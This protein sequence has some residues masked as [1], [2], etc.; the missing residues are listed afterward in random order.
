MKFS[1]TLVA[2]AATAAS[3][4]LEPITMKGS[5]LFYTNGTQFFMKGVAY[6][7]DTAAAGETNDKTTKYI[8]PLADEEA[9]KRD[10]PL[11]KELGTNIIRTYA[12]NPKADHK[13]CMKMLDDAGIYVVS[14]LSE[15]SVSINRDDPKWDIELYER[16]IGVVDELAQYD[17]VVG[18]F[19]GNEV[20]NN[21]SNTQASAFVKAA[22]RDTKAHIK[23]KYDRWLG[24]G[25]AS[26]DDVDIRED[27]ADYFNCGKDEERIDYWGYNIY[28]WCG[29]SNMKDSGYSDQAKF[30][31]DYS[32]P[33]F[34]A[35]YGCNEP[36]GAAERIFDETTALYE[37]KEMVDVFSGGIVYMYY[38]EANDY[39]LVKVSKN[40][41]AV[42][43][44]DFAQLKKKANA[45]HAA[46]VDESDYKPTAKAATCPKQSESW[47]VNAQLPPTP[48]SKLCDCMKKSRSCVPA[49]DLKAKDFN[50]IFGYICGENEKICTAINGNATTGVYGAYSMCD[51]EAKLAYILDAYYKDQKKAADACDFK[52][53]ATT[54]KAQNEDSCQSALESA[55]KINDEVATA[56]AAVGASSTDGSS[57]EEDDESFGLQAASIARVFS[58]GDYAVGAYMAVAGAVGAGMVLL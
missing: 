53:K 14:D 52:G 54:Q 40:G 36:G 18:F 42:K 35:E 10:I 39:G 38:Q 48:D 47:K 4:K 27:I 7:Q 44:K 49:D 33:V 16:Y 31:K 32:V 2:A 20:S 19:A 13:A 56:T 41:A 23:S 22:V 29:E 26:N 43:Q 15:P 51:N 17:N 3:A 21:V 50:S 28:S 6:Q 46:G 58:L 11:L 24:V 55:S 45:A 12:I 30:F 5:K 57:S 34:F 1:A 25:Y 8:D 37:E 9:C